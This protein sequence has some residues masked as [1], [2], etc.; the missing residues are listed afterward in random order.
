[1]NCVFEYLIKIKCNVI[2]T[3]DQLLITVEYILDVEPR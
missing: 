3:F 1:M 2:F